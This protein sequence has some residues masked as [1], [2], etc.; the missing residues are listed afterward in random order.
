MVS[1][2]L[3]MLLEN[4][5]LEEGLI[6]PKDNRRWLHA[7][8]NPY[9]HFF[10]GPPTSTSTPQEATKWSCL[11]RPQT[12]CRIAFH[13]AL[14]RAKRTTTLNKWETDFILLLVHMHSPYEDF[15]WG[16]HA[17]RPRHD[18]D[19]YVPP[20]RVV[21]APDGDPLTIGSDPREMTAQ[22]HVVNSVSHSSIKVM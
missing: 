21:G 7:G 20:Y 10:K 17:G 16:Q 19:L 15:R 6:S 8:I 22:V 12:Q 1:E 13:R 4:F 14:Q 9:P 11:T 2:T 18:L 5:N 3:N